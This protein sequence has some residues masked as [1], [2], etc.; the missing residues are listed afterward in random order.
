[1]KIEEIKISKIKPNPNNPRLIKDEAFEKLVK[2]IKEFPEMLSIRPIVI[3]EDNIV[4]GGNMRLK[5]C[6]AAG[7]KNVP[8]IRAKGLTQEQQKE[9]IIKDNVSGG[10]WAWDIL[11]NEWNTEELSEWGLEVPDFVDKSEAQEDEFDVPEGGIETDIVLGDLFE[12]G[13][14]RLLCGDSTCSDTVAKLMNGEKADMVFT[15][16]PYNINYGN[17]KHPKFKQRDIENDNMSGDQFKDFCN[18]FASNI[19]LFCDGVV[20]CWAGPG[21]D[22]RIMFTCLDETLH[23]STM[24]VWN[25]DQFTLGRGKYQNKNEVCWFGWNVSGATFTEDRK[26]TNVWDF[27]RPKRSE[28]HPTMKPIKLIENGLNHNPSAKSVLDLFLGSGST[29]VA[30]HQLNRKC[31]GIELDPKYCQVIINRMLNLDPSIKIKLNGKPY[32]KLS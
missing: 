26:L 28:L 29:M 13:Q 23:N 30:S 22:G 24:I 2:S 14:H 6:I 12:I 11:A 15:D 27:E 19:K 7:L 18:A 4:L 20:Y 3:N 5:A 10:E 16:P 31:Y 9:F 8:I 1:M 25:K 21:K 32:Q 17:I